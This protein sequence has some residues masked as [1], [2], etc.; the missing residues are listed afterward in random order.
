MKS[1]GVIN[2]VISKLGHPGQTI[3]LPI[4]TNTIDVER[5]EKQ[6]KELD[7]LF[8]VIGSPYTFKVIESIIIGNETVKVELN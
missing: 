3:P 5:I 7:A 4:G 2:I 6:V 8:A 1:S